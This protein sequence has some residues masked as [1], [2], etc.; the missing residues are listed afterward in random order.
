KI[1]KRDAELHDKVD[2]KD[3]VK[4]DGRQL[5]FPIKH[6]VI[7]NEPLGCITSKRAFR[8]SKTIYEF[9]PNNCLELFHAG[10][11]DKETNGLLLLTNDGDLSNQLLHPKFRIIRVYDV[12]LDRQPDVRKILKGVKLEDGFSK[13]LFVKQLPGDKHRIEV[14]LAEGRKRQIRRTL[15]EMGYRIKE[16][17]RVRF[18]PI[19]LGD[20]KEGE[21]RELDAKEI[22][23]LK[24][25]IEI[26]VPSYKARS[27]RKPV[28]KSAYSKPEGRVRRSKSEPWK[29]P[30]GEKRTGTEKRSPTGKPSK[31]RVP[32]GRSSKY[33]KPQ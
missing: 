11:L 29:R 22:V 28:N 8:E 20:L 1:G 5:T 12:E 25:A 3:V 27:D 10:R 9:L 13:F 16:L 30:E 23:S 7:F 31:N 21:C 6:Y 17:T 14:K 4:F 26:P 15:W 2:E 18:G 33:N 19:R 32:K 24:R